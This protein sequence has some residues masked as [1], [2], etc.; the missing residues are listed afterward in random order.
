M[1]FD[2]LLQQIRHTH[3]HLQQSAVK[4][5]NVH[6]TIRNWLVGYYIVEFEQK[7]ENRAAYGTKLLENIAKTINIKGLTA[8]E[9]SRSR[10][11]YQTYSDFQATLHRKFSTLVPLPILGS[12]TQELEQKGVI[13][14]LGLPTQ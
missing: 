8:P 7:G 10:Q 2:D 3:S 5:V 12:V 4:A 6:I 9:L 14:I 1:T 11:F 13:S